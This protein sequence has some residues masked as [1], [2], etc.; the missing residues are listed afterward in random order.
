MNKWDELFK[1][2]TLLQPTT[3]NNLMVDYA[4]NKL[5]MVKGNTKIVVYDGPF[6]IDKV[7]LVKAIKECDHHDQLATD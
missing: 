7:K 2:K 1:V 5:L 6:P 4:E 3:K